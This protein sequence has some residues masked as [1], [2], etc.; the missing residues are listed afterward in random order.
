[1]IP[2]YNEEARLPGS[3][4]RLLAFLGAQAFESEVIVSDDGSTDATPRITRE[5]ASNGTPAN[6]MLR[7]VQ[8]YPNRGKGAAIR[9]GMMAAEGDYAF[10]LDADLATPPE[11][12]SKLIRRL[13][14]GLDVVIGNRI[15]PDGSDMRASQPTRRRLVGRLFTVMRKRLGILP[16]IDDTQCPIKGFRRDVARAVFAEQTLTGWTFDAEVLCIA[17]SLGYRIDQVPVS[18]RHIDGSRLRVGPSQALAIARDLW[19]LRGRQSNRAARR[20]EVES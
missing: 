9:E 12:S 6:T 13:E 11:D 7:L 20:R 5:R 1:V 4:D 15:Q 10:F 8:H 17:R 3:L 16:D 14:D 18:W 19:R 2:A